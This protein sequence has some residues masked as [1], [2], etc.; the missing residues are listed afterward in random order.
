LMSDDE[1][2]DLKIWWLDGW[3]GRRSG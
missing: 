1:L 2:D 3:L